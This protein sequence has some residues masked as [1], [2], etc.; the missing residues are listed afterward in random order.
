M[1]FIT[2]MLQYTSSLRSASSAL[3]LTLVCHLFKDI[4]NYT[5]VIMKLQFTLLIKYLNVLSSNTL[6]FNLQSRALLLR[7]TMFS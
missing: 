3:F 4:C 1:Y 7:F 6:Q 2:V 5:F